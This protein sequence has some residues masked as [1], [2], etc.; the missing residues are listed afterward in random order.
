V[1]ARLKDKH[2]FFAA[3]NHGQY[4]HIVPQ[5]S[6][7]L[8][9]GSIFSLATIGFRFRERLRRRNRHFILRNALTFREILPI[10]LLGI[11]D[12]LLGNGRG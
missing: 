10:I 1:N 3:G 2:H 6:F 8:S 11:E 5:N 4:I 9:T 12:V 7:P